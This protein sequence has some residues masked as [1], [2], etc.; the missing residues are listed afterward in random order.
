VYENTVSSV[1]SRVF[2]DDFGGPATS[3]ATI[4]RNR[5]LRG[6]NVSNP[7]QSDG[8]NGLTYALTPSTWDGGAFLGGNYWNEFGATGNPDA[9]HPYTAFIGNVGGGPNVDR[10]PFQ[11]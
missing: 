10:F 1:G 8:L 5:F 6:T 2:I 7:P 4:F 11:S 3:G 9:T